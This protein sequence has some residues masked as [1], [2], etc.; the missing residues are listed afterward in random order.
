MKNNTKA[1]TLIELLVVIAII[2][3]LAAILF[4]VFAQA[5]QAAKN[6][7]AISN[8]NQIGKAAMMYASDYDDSYAPRRTQT[9]TPSTPRG[10]T[11]ASWKQLQHPYVKSAQVWSDPAN[12]ASKF[13]DDTSDPIVNAIDNWDMIEPR[14]N[15]GYAVNNMFWLT[16]DWGGNGVNGSMFDDVAGTIYMMETKSVWVDYG[17]YIP[18]CNATTNPEGHCNDPSSEAWW[19]GVPR[20]WPGGGPNWGGKKWEDK[21]FVAAFVDGHTKRTS[22]SQ[23]CNRGGDKT[24][25][26]YERSKL[27]NGY[28]AGGLGWLETLCDTVRTNGRM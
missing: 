26:G 1:F 10:R 5:K 3:I 18:F 4:P 16:G 11:I 17:V 24:M 2:A 28:F 15:R 8:M 12:P 14:L 23:A 20:V 25:W 22:F 7:Q 21:A 9:I 6:T 19:P 27:A 13:P